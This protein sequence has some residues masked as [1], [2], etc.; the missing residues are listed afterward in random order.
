MKKN[1]L[2]ILMA[3]SLV[4]TFAAIV[5]AS[6]NQMHQKFETL[7]GVLTSELT[8]KTDNGSIYTLSGSDQ[9]LAKY[10]GHE[11]KVVGW[12]NE[13]ST[14]KHDGGQINVGHLNEIS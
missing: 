9:H 6:A 13:N 14:L 1:F 5:P 10:V 2:S 12:V 11:V 4:M 3:I 7:K 8:L